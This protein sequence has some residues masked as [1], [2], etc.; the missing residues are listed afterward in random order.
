MEYSFSTS[1]SSGLLAAAA[2]IEAG[3]VNPF[4]LYP[5]R[6]HKAKGA[7]A[8]YAGRARAQA[9]FF[10]ES[11]EEEE[12]GHFLDAC[13]LCKKPL[14]GHLDIF[15]YRGD[16]PFCSEECRQ[17]QIEADE[18]KET[19]RKL[20]VTASSRREFEEQKITLVAG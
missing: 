15:M 4:A 5:P 17:Q 12:R 14:A 18:A 10:C 11:L 13:F 3:F 1:S 20:S 9:R 2:D 16:L 8:I 19:N 6:P 7:A